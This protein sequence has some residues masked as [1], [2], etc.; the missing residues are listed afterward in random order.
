MATTRVFAIG[1][2]HGDFKPVR[3]FYQGVR[4]NIPKSDK[5]VLVCLGDFGGNY[6]FNHRDEEY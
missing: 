6:F 2:I 5:V 4:K 3:T 1:D